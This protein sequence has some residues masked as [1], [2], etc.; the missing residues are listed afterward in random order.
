MANP[1]RKHSG[2]SGTPDKNKM[3]MDARR[4]PK[5][6]HVARSEKL[7]DMTDAPESGE[8]RE[9]GRSRGRIIDGKDTHPKGPRAMPTRD[10]SG[11]TANDAWEEG[12]HEAMD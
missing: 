8:P 4:T 1:S 11:D 7:D 5:M 6:I 2:R 3:S 9:Q 10:Q 12:R